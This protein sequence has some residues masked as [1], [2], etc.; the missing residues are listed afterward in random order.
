MATI[1]Q[2][3]KRNFTFTPFLNMGLP[4]SLVLP[5]YYGRVPVLRLSSMFHCPRGTV[6]LPSHYRQMFRFLPVHRS[7]THFSS[8]FRGFSSSPPAKEDSVGKIQSTHYHLIYTCK[9]CSTRS[10]QKISK[11]AY[12]KGVVI[13]TCPECKNHHIIADNLNWFSDLEGKRN[14]EEIL[15]AKGE[16]VKKIEGSSALEMVV[17]E[18]ST[19]E[20]Q[21]SDS[22][23]KI[24]KNSEN[25]KE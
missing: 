17:N 3:L 9:V 2:N 20:T 21:Q 12:H 16:T 10:T 4:L 25:V 23:K 15:A 1:M 18:S 6:Q 8:N 22:M 14:I 19:E 11:L 13:V 5:C 24:D 7:E